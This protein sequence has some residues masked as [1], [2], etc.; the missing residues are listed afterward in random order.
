M[1]GWRRS[2]VIRLIASDLD[3]TIIDSLGQCDPSVPEEIARVRKMGVKF[4]VCSG[5]PID[6]MKEVL[7]GWNLHEV[8]DYII[9]SNGGEVLEISTGKRVQTY[10]LPADLLN[11]IIDLYE[12]QGLIPAV[13]DGT[14]LYTQKITPHTRIIEKRIGVHLVRTDIRTVLKEPQVKIMFMMEPEQMAAAEA[15]AKSHNSTKYLVFKTAD[16]LLEVS[17][18]LL[19]KSVGLRII[20]AMMQITPNEMMAFGDTTNDIGMLEYVRYGICMANGTADAKAVSADE[21]PS[22]ADHGF[23]R[24]LQEHLSTP[25]YQ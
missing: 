2:E 11:E 25:V 1:F 5:R 8:T 15:F 20:S 18:P 6:S 17:H 22:I 21:A 24:Y 7:R 19:D 9:G 4:S 23:A 14:A 3:G 10:S 13:Y 12:P 16:D